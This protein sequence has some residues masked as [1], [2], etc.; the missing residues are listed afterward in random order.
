MS[1][2]SP[3][4][5]FIAPLQSSGGYGTTAR[6]LSKHFPPNTEMRTYVGFQFK[7]TYPTDAKPLDDKV[8]NAI[9]SCVA[10]YALPGYYYYLRKKY[11]FAKRLVLITAGAESFE[12]MEEHAAQMIQLDAVG[13]TSPF[14]HN[15]YTKRGI[16]AHMIRTYS[17]VA[18]Q[19]KLRF[20]FM[21][22]YIKRK[23]VDTL[24]RVFKQLKTKANL[25][26]TLTLKLRTPSM[27]VS[28]REMMQMIGYK[29]TDTDLEHTDEN[30]FF[31]RKWDEDVAPIYQQHGN[32]ISLSHAEGE[33]IPFSDARAM[34]LKIWSAAAPLVHCFTLPDYEIPHKVGFIGDWHLSVKYGRWIDYN[35]DA[36]FDFLV[37]KIK[38]IIYKDAEL[39]R[40][41]LRKLLFEQ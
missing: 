26:V 3:K 31:T 8:D 1:F 39:L 35:E 13:V 14:M 10:L 15:I 29:Q 23:N 5:L 25:P 2:D 6:L 19:R 32:Y 9:Y 20:L 41:D 11:P 17:T 4:T 33:N 22:Q 18:A 30:I 40:G 38:D 27:D 12:I 34:G 36:V 21:G 28:F 16:N 7:E 24:V 37:N